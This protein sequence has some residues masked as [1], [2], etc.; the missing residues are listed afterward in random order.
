MSQVASFIL[1]M[2]GTNPENQKAPEG[3]LYKAETSETTD[4]TAT[5]GTV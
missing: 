1:T 2:V 4:S 3:E 5:E